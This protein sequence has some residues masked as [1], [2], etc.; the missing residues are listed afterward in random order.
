[1]N[2]KA[3]RTQFDEIEAKRPGLGQGPRWADLYRLRMTEFASE[4]IPKLLDRVAE[5]EQRVKELQ[6]E[7]AALDP[8]S[9]L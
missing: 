2:L 5:L 1:M 3:I 8:L 4:Q 7:N 9:W 6:T